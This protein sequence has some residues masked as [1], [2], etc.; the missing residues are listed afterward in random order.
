[1]SSAA[2]HAKAG[3]DVLAALRATPPASPGEPAAEAPV[4]ATTPPSATA[5]ARVAAQALAATPAVPAR[6]AKAPRP[7]KEARPARE[8]RPPKAARAPKARPPRA[9]RRTPAAAVGPVAPAAPPVATAP[10]V[11]TASA[12]K[13]DRLVV[14]PKK[15]A[16]RLMGLLLM[17]LLPATA[18]AI[19]VAAST[20]DTT[21]AGVAL[22]LGAL[23]LGLWFMRV[24]VVPTTVSIVG[25]QLEV[26][27]G[28]EVH[29]W[30]LAS[31][32]SPVD[33]IRSRPGRSGWRVVMRAA[34]GSLFTIDAT[35]VPAKRFMEILKRYRP[36]L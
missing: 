30:D 23:T 6:R 25:P 8:P 29:R 34:D 20:R 19:W 9:E 11:V 12:A 18:L 24:L 3:M 26:R 5:A 32:Y 14:P 27:R 17:G 2:N 35:M 21:L 10:P 31:V 28:D 16:R 15:A 1:M 7:A 33:H 4:E 36:E 22:I 13:D